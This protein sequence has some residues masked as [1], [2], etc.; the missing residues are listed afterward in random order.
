MGNVSVPSDEGG[1]GA[2]SIK[3]FDG[4]DYRLSRPDLSFAVVQCRDQ[5]RG[6]YLSS[7]LAWIDGRR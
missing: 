7:L 6:L 2:Q 5:D 1:E 3:V 4:G